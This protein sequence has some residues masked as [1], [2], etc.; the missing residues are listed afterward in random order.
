MYV[1]DRINNRVQVFTIEGKYLREV[2]I[3]RKSLGYGTA[4]DLAFSPDANQTYLYVA[5]STNGAVRI[6]HRQSL[7]LLASFGQ[8]GHQAGQ[9]DH[10]H[11]I[12]V[13]SRGN[14]YTGDVT[15]ATIQRW[16]YKGT[17]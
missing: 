6:L 16:V 4:M 1:A 8:L 15:G 11:N 9:L 17:S 2:F 7:Q 3:Q 14:V 13:D 10:V 12:A 5:D